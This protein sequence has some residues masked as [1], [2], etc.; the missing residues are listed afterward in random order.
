MST[1]DSKDEPFT[2]MKNTLEKLEDSDKASE[3]VTV[4][5]ENP[6]SAVVSRCFVTDNDNCLRLWPSISAYGSY[7]TT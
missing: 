5:S 2:T 1:R 7:Q 3:Y 6:Y 4:M